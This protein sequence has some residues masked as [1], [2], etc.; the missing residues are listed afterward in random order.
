VVVRRLIA[1]L[2]LVA[3][4]LGIV[5]PALACAN[6]AS[7]TDCCPA[8]ASAGSGERMCPASPSI[9]AYGCCA[10]PAAGTSSVAAVRARAPQG[11]ASGS[12]VALDVPMGVPL[13]QHLSAP[14]TAAAPIRYHANESLTYLLTARLRL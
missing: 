4:L 13:G 3:C 1:S 12:P 7:R 5:Q 10:L 8:G 2:V 14:R 11:H 6:N 9:E